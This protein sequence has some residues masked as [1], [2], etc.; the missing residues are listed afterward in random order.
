[1]SIFKKYLLEEPK[2]VPEE[3]KEHLLEK[4]KY[5][6]GEFG[7]AGTRSDHRAVPKEEQLSIDL[8]NKKVFG[9][10]NKILHW[11]EHVFKHLFPRYA[12]FSEIGT[13][14]QRDFWK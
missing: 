1:M 10:A 2:R 6:A 7:K 4:F 13:K 8:G 12:Y 5:A 11:V 3:R 14:E 9:V